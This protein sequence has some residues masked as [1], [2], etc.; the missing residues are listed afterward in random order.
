MLFFWHTQRLVVARQAHAAL[1]NV[2]L[3]V[4]A[5]IFVDECVDSGRPCQL[6]L[7]DEVGP[8]RLG[9]PLVL[10]GRLADPLL[11]LVDPVD[12]LCVV[13]GD[14]EDAGGFMAR[15]PEVFNEKDELQSILVGNSIVLALD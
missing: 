5:S 3:V 13:V 6:F 1:T 14:A 9:V 7:P 12:H 11:V 4:T 2:V 10:L 8:D 15:H